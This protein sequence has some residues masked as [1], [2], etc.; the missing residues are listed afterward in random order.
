MNVNAGQIRP[1]DTTYN[2]FSNKGK[3]TDKDHSND[4]CAYIFVTDMGELMRDNGFELFVV[5]II[6]QAACQRNGVIAI[7]DA[8]GK[9]VHL[10]RFNDHKTRHGLSARNG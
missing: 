7:F 10:R 8:A 4:E 5:K 9:G 3:Y 1:K 6:H 2:A